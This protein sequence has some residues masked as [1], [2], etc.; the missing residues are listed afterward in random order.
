M[1]DLFVQA[2]GSPAASTAPVENSPTAGSVSYSNSPPPARRTPARRT[3]AAPGGASAENAGNDTG[4]AGNAPPPPP[5]PLP[6][7]QQRVSRRQMESIVQATNKQHQKQNTREA[8]NAKQLQYLEFCDACY[9]TEPPAYRHLVD[10]DKTYYFI[11]YQTF[12][13]KYEAKGRQGREKFDLSDYHYVTQR[14]GHYAFGEDSVQIPDPEKPLS[15]KSLDQYRSAIRDLHTEQ[16]A[17]RINRYTWNEIWTIYSK[18][19]IQVAAGRSKRVAR[20]NNEERVDAATEPFYHVGQIPV[21]EKTFWDHGCNTRYV[22]SVFASLRHRFNFLMDVAAILRNE[23]LV[24]ADLSDLGCFNVRRAEDHDAMPIALMMIHTGKT[25][26]KNSPPQFGRATR[27]KDVYSCPLGALGMYL[28]YRFEHG[29]DPQFKDVDVEYFVRD[30]SWFNIK[31]LVKF[32]NEPGVD[33]KP[34]ENEK[35]MSQDPF[36][37]AIKK[38]L[39]KNH[40]H[41]KHYGHLGRCVGPL[42]AEFN[43]LEPDLIKVLG[44]F[45]AHCCALFARLLG[46]VTNTF[47]NTF[48]CFSLLFSFLS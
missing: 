5:P 27:H 38:N 36:V 20:A 4:N 42:I 26:K 9:S 13:N 37:T 8:Y 3:G 1:V 10:P 48:T 15:E 22:R 45:F 17:A 34:G 33:G 18:R 32:D 14:W 28:L 40:I 6:L 11:F 25:V 46:A 47:T 24:L 35:K 43:E 30:N 21:I 23:S 39:Q 44:K 41:S 12:R 31:L 19:L 29:C 7:H 16:F 2:F